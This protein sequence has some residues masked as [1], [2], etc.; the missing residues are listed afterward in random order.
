MVQDA[1]N[2]SNKRN[3]FPPGNVTSFKSY[4]QKLQN[5]QFWLATT[6]A[7]IQVQKEHTRHIFLLY[8]IA[9]ST[10]CAPTKD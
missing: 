2:S 7:W 1:A 8:L 5:R 3:K 10:G 9:L 6:L 4:L